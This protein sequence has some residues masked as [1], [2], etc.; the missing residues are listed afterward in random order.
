LKF[1]LKLLLFPARLNHQNLRF[2]VI[3]IMLGNESLRPPGSAF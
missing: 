3:P 1:G 2:K